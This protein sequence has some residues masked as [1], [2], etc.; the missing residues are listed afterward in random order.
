MPP[1]AKVPLVGDNTAAP[2]LV[3][4]A[5]VKRRGK[6]GELRHAEPQGLVGFL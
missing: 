5:A 1:A 3:D 2:A 4:L 6:V